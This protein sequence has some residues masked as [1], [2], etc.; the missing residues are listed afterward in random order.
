MHEGSHSYIHMGYYNAFK[1]LGYET[2]WIDS[3]DD[4]SQYTFKDAIFLVSVSGAHVPIDDSNFYILHNCDLNTFTNGEPKHKIILQV[5]THSILNRSIE[6]IEDL[7]YYDKND[8]VL[9]QPWATDL[10]PNLFGTDEYYRS[11]KSRVK[12]EVWWVGSIWGTDQG[13]MSEIRQV[14]D[15]LT[16]NNIQFKTVVAELSTQ[17]NFEMI[18]SSLYSLAIQGKW[19]VDNGYIPCRIYKNIS[20]GRLTLTNSPTVAKHIGYGAVLVNDINDI[21]S[22][23]KTIENNIDYNGLIDSINFIKNNH[24]YINRINNIIKFI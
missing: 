9:Y 21:L 4:L 23:G 22:I 15:I 11:Y 16:N 14:A 6:R 10:L 13:N 3:R 19:Q 2:Y 12:N 1:E 17:Q 8:N 24:T 20:Y 18:N 7:C 5:Y